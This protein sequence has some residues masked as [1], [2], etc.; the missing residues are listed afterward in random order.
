MK[1]LQINS[2]CGVGSTGRIATNIH[3]LL[4]QQGYES[5]I[6]YGRGK[7]NRCEAVIRIGNIFDVLLHI[8]KSRLFDKHGLGSKK[9]TRALV[10]AITEADPDLI[11]L[12]NIHGYYVNYEILFKYLIAQDKPV[13]WTLHDCWSFTGHCAYYDLSGCNKWMLECK[14]CML[15]KS[16][17]KSYFADNS[18]NNY[19]LKKKYLMKMKNIMLVTPSE[20]LKTEVSKSFLSD[21]DCIVV[22]NGINISVFKPSENHLRSKLGLDEK[23][24]YLGVANPWSKRK[25]LRFFYEMSSLLNSDEI[26]LLIGLDRIQLK[27]LPNNILG[28]EKTDSVVE[29]ARI[30]SL[31]NVFINPTLEDNYPTTNLEAIACGL[32]IVTFDTG[33]SAEC[34]EKYSGKS[35]KEKSADALLRAARELVENKITNKKCDKKYVSMDYSVNQYIDIYKRMLLNTNK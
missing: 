30:Y 31:S 28:F 1:I 2:V 25:G 17:P 32:P 9:S 24:V 15:K 14:K 22:H 7:A 33:G 19:R 16:Y 26:I 34:L 11:H 20:W 3:E 13:V 23:I 27:S 10:N 8:V 35:V 12:H 18:M 6:A 29:L 5:L 4:L 21:R